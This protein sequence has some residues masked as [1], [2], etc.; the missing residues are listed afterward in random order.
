M[1]MPMW[2]VMLPLWSCYWVISFSLFIQSKV[3]PNSV[4]GTTVWMMLALGIVL[5]LI[6]PPL[7]LGLI[8]IDGLNEWFGDRRRVAR[9]ACRCGRNSLAC[10]R[11]RD[12]YAVLGI[13]DDRLV[14]AEAGLAKLAP[15][16]PRTCALCTHESARHCFRCCRRA[17][18]EERSRARG[19]IS[20][21]VSGVVTWSVAD[22][23]PSLR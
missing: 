22:E 1:M 21:P 4:D 14:A 3:A 15:G 17:M 9:G 7:H 16:S 18:L 20:P 23:S 2:V 5:L 6:T 10:T 19:W 11:C 12:A 8:V 13:A